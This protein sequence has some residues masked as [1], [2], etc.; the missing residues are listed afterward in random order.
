MFVAPNPAIGLRRQRKDRVFHRRHVALRSGVENVADEEVRGRA[1]GGKKR[2]AIAVILQGH[3]VTFVISHTKSRSFDRSP[4]RP[5]H[6]THRDGRFVRSPTAGYKS[7]RQVNSLVE[8][9]RSVTLYLTQVFNTHDRPADNAS[10]IA[11]QRNDPLTGSPSE[12]RDYALNELRL[13][14]QPTVRAWTN[15]VLP[16]VTRSGPSSS[17]RRLVSAMSRSTAEPCQLVST[18]PERE[19]AYF[20]I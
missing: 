7:V 12:H 18:T 13:R 6:L 9:I 16:W 5:R 14:Q 20:L 1:P 3:G 4:T 2:G 10:Q 8:A 17:R 11:N 19:T 15:S